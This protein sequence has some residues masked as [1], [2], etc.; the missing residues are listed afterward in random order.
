MVGCDVSHAVQLRL[1]I[2]AVTME[3]RDDAGFRRLMP[4][5]RLVGRG[6]IFWSRRGSVSGC[7]SGLALSRRLFGFRVNDRGPLDKFRRLGS[8]FGRRCF[9]GLGFGRPG[10]NRF[11]RLVARSHRQTSRAAGVRRRGHQNH[12]RDQNEFA[13]VTLH[14]CSDRRVSRLDRSLCEVHHASLDGRDAGRFGAQRYPSPASA[15][16]RP[17]SPSQTIRA[18]SSTYTRSACGSAKV[19]FCSPS[20]TVI[21]VV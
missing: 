17:G 6:K 7:R 13:H 21:G 12:R 14:V 18:C 1:P 8:C 10:F 9:C 4:A 19:T 11:G 2:D 15:A 16:N 3:L 5:L 20:R